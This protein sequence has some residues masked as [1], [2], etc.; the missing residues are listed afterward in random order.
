MET[1]VQVAT[2][3]ESDGKLHLDNLPFK[4]GESVEVTII[5]PRLTQHRPFGLC[6]GEFVVPDDFDAPLPEE[7]LRDFEG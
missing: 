5:A 7:I 6:A 1:I 4:A 3:L 2:K